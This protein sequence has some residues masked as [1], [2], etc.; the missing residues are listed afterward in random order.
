MYTKKGMMSRGREE[1]EEGGI[2][3]ISDVWY[4]KEKE[5]GR[6]QGEKTGY[7]CSSCV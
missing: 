2:L 4:A 1:E 3:R 6:T 5:K 7:A